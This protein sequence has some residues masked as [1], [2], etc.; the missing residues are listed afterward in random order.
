MRL[1]YQAKKRSRGPKANFNPLWPSER[2]VNPAKIQ[3]LRQDLEAA[4]KH[5][6]GKDKKGLVHLYGSST[7]LTALGTPDQSS[8]ERESDCESSS[9][10]DISD[11]DPCLN[12]MSSKPPIS[13]EDFFTHHVH[14]SPVHA[15]EIEE[16]TQQSKLPLWFSERRLR[17]TVSE[18][19]TIYRRKGN[20]FRR[21]V[22]DHLHSQLTGNA[23]TRYGKRM[24]KKAIAA[25]EEGLLL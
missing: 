5:A 10:S 25:F 21:V 23:A 7:W 1:R 15:A 11:V 3:Q 20:A 2:V 12:S 6:R 22:R 8:S 9:S 14:V 4:D 16:K 17:A 24:E 13:P 19:K 18:A